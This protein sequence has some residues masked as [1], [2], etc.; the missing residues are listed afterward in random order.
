LNIVV[1]SSWQLEELSS[2]DSTFKRKPLPLNRY[3]SI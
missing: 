3:Q 1:L 2:I